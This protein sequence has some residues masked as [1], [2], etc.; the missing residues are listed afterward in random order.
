MEK[1]VVYETSTLE[2]G[3]VKYKKLLGKF[4]TKYEAS[5]FSMTYREAESLTTVHHDDETDLSQVG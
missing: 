3:S 4:D 2:D 5:A 1:F